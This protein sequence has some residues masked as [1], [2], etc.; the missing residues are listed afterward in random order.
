[1]K[2]KLLSICIALMVSFSLFYAGFS[3]AKAEE[4]KDD[5]YKNLDLF[6]EALS[7]IQKKYV[8]EKPSKELM[9]GAVRGVLSSLDVYSQFLE[10]EDYK[11]LLV[12]TEGKFGGLGIEITIR[13]GLLTIV[14]PIEDTP[15]WEAGVQ[16]GDIIVKIDD[17][18]TKNITLHEAVKKLRGKPGTK[19]K[20]T[21]L[22][23]KDRR[24]EEITITRDTIQIKDIK[25]AMLLKDDIAYIKL[26][27]FRES[28]AKDLNKALARLEKEGMKGLILDLRNNPGGLLDSAI[29]VS[30]Q[31]LKDSTLVV[32][33]K[34]RDGKE[35]K[36][37]SLWKK[38]K[39]VKLPMVVM[40][41]KGSASG[42]EIVAAALKENKRAI[43]LG[44][45]SFGK[46]SVQTVVPLSDG[47]ALKFTTAKYYT[48]L[49]NSL[50]EKGIEPDI[51]I[52]QKETEEN[53]EDVFE[54]MK[55]ERNEEFDY[56]KD[57]QIIRALDLIKGLIILSAI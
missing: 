9:Y 24:L 50:H 40:I 11:E 36:Y 42:S 7:L 28:T 13:E 29:D 55:E 18:V 26:L 12:K 41:N 45:T 10:P 32:Y 4:G 22:R 47:S 52:E 1:M 30:S 6:G 2:K 44:E 46:G 14:S 15:A 51:V 54:Q 49:G 5:I 48:P 16:A 33:T 21:V 3:Q 31:F 35:D 34:T 27:E 19:V 43:L 23:E 8:E 25:H 17:E 57:Y 39:Y 37:N 38:N 53:P 56:K 20:L